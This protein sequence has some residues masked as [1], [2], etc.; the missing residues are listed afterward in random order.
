MPIAEPRALLW[1]KDRFAGI[2][3][4]ESVPITEVGSPALDPAIWQAWDETVG[5]VPSAAFQQPIGSGRW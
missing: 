1:P 5:A 3:V 4:A 2:P